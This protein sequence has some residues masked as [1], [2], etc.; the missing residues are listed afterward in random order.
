[1]DANNRPVC[2]YF[3]CGKDFFNQYNLRRHIKAKHLGQKYICPVCAKSLASPQS[4]REHH[5]IH[6][7][8]MLYKCTFQ[9]CNLQFRQASQLSLHRRQHANQESVAPMAGLPSLVQEELQ[10]FWSGRS[11]VPFTTLP[12]PFSTGDG[13]EIIP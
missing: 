8:A 2:E 12:D 7:G 10:A 4:L 3:G 9:G 1:M 13:S 5:A 6:T 11:D